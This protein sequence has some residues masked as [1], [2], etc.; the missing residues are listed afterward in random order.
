VLDGYAVNPGDLSWKAF[1]ELGGLTVYDRTAPH[2]L[3]ERAVSADAVIV[4]SLGFSEAVFSQLPRLRYL[5]LVATGYDH[6][7]LA[8]AE[9]HGVTVCNV[10][11][12]GT[13]SVAQAAFALLLTLAHRVTEYDAAVHAGHWLAGRP[14]RYLPQ[15]LLEINGKILGVV[16]FG[17]IGAAVAALGRAFAMPV[18]AYD[19]SSPEQCY[20]AGVQRVELGQLLRQADVVSL[21]LPLTSKTRKLINAEALKLMKAGA[22][23]IN[24]ARGGLVDDAALAAALHEG[25]IAG[26]GLDVLGSEEPPDP[27]NPLL[28]A[29]NCVITPHIAWATPEARGRCV[30]EAAAN[31]KAF[32]RG[33]PRNAIVLPPA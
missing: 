4:D 29:P 32:Q 9:A 31:L 27:G 14:Y 2:Q 23:F 13:Q 15:P 26:A 33:E 17:R 6:V 30:A 28:T 18:L 3:V 8:A 1:A 7:D 19:E 25:R 24:T 16:G 20:T 10:P 12:Y 11:A 21:H 22:L 5:G